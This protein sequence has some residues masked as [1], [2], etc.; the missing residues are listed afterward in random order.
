MPYDICEETQPGD[1]TLDFIENAMASRGITQQMIDEK[2][3]LPQLQMYND[4]QTCVRQ[5]RTQIN[6]SSR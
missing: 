2:R 5:V 6:N 1:K 4:L 3:A